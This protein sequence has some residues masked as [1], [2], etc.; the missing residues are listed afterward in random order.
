M[1][2]F[3]IACMQVFPAVQCELYFTSFTAHTYIH[4]NGKCCVSISVCANIHTV[5]HFLCHCM[6]SMSGNCFESL[7]IDCLATA[8][9]DIITMLWGA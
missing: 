9:S 1:G 2:I 7:S 6:P 5:A 3:N 8:C 4:I